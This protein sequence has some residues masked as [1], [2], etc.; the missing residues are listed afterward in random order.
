[1]DSTIITVLLTSAVSIITTLI[2]SSKNNALQ[3][4]RIKVVQSDITKLASK[5]EQ[6]NNFG[7]SIAKIETRLETLERKL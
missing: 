3:D 2:T 4:E 7:L 6:H 1:M 5:V